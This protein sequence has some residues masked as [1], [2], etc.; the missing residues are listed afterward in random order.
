MKGQSRIIPPPPNGV[1][2]FLLKNDLDPF[3]HVRSVSFAQRPRAVTGGGFYD[4]SARY[5]AVREE[6]RV[7]LRQYLMDSID[8]EKEDTVVQVAESLELKQYLDLP[9]VALSNGQTRRA[10]IVR[11]LLRQPKV[12]LLD[13]PLSKVILYSYYA[14]LIIYC[15]SGSRCASQT[16]FDIS[17][18]FFTQSISA[19]YNHVFEDPGSCT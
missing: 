18:S 17:S 8:P 2:P 10:R 15:H 14:G 6:D 5:G 7:T 19:T 13:E 1:W 9:L 3:E 16:S 12:L 11:A 4:Y